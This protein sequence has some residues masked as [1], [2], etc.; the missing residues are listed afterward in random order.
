[1]STGHIG[2]RGLVE[3]TLF[4]LET[5]SR[6][7][8]LVLCRVW[9]SPFV[10]RDSAESGGVTI[11]LGGLLVGKLVVSL[12]TLRLLDEGCDRASICTSIFSFL[13]GGFSPSVFC[14]VSKCFA[15]RFGGFLVFWI[16]PVAEAS[17]YGWRPAT[18]RL[19]RIDGREDAAIVLPKMKAHLLCN[20][21]YSLRSQ[22]TSRSCS[23]CE[24]QG[25]FYVFV[26]YLG[27]SLG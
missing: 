17:T 12:A 5:S 4:V 16:V 19:E 9:S 8:F 18:R 2:S 24:W 21:G 25:W 14:R 13:L 3:A 11:V 7:A 27:R 1:L 22:W 15:R 10:V 20:L 26:L 6:C 23:S